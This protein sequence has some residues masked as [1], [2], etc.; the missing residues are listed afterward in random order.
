MDATYQ[1]IQAT[2][3]EGNVD[4]LKQ[5]LATHQIAD[6]EIHSQLSGPY[7]ELTHR[8]IVLSEAMEHFVEYELVKGSYRNAPNEHHGSGAAKSADLAARTAH[9]VQCIDLI[10]TDHSPDSYTDIDELLVVRLRHVYAHVF[11]LKTHLRRLPLMQLQFCIAVFLKLVTGK[12]VNGFDVYA[13]TIDKERLIRFLKTIRDAMT[14][15]TRPVISEDHYVQ[16]VQHLATGPTALKQLSRAPPKRIR[17]Y[18]QRQVKTINPSTLEDIRKHVLPFAE[19]PPPSKQTLKSLYEK[20]IDWDHRKRSS[21]TFKELHETYFITKQHYSI[22]KVI[23]YIDG[24][25][26]GP[27][28]DPPHRQPPVAPSPTRIRA[29]KR[30]LQ[31]IGEMIKSTRESPNITAK[32]SRVLQL[33]TSEALAE[34]T[35][36]LRQFF[37][38]GYS[39]AKWEL[40]A[41]RCDQLGAVFQKIEINLREA[42]RW[43]VYTQTQQNL[44][45]YRRYLAY[46]KRFRTI[47]ALR[48]YIAFVGTEF[49]GSLIETYAPEQL[50]EAKLLVQYM[51][52]S[53]AESSL[54]DPVTKDDLKYIVKDLQLRIN[55]IR[56]ENASVGRTIDEFFFLESYI[57]QPTATVDRVRQT[58]RY[59]LSH[60]QLA[61]RHKLVQKTDLMYARELLAR[62]QLAEPDDTRRYMWS[63]IWTRLSK[64]Q[65]G[66]LDTLVGRTEQR[67]DVA[68][69]A[70][71]KTMHALHLPLDDDEYVQ[72][73]NRR[74]AKSY[75][76]N[77]FVLDNK[78]RVL[79]EIVKDRRAQQ[80]AD[81]RAVPL[82]EQLKTLR[83]QDEHMFQRMFDGL[84]DSMEQILGRCDR[85]TGILPAVTDQ[86]A[87]EYCLLEA[88]EILCNLALFRDNAADLATMP[89]PVVTGRNLR[90]Y[91]AHDMLA[92]D[93]L[94]PC[95]NAVVLN[96]RYLVEH[97]FKLYGAAGAATKLILS[98]KDPPGETLAKKLH[99]K[100]IFQQQTEWTVEQVEFF[101]IVTNFQTSVLQQRIHDASETNSSVDLLLLGRN[102]LDQEIVTIA[103]H[104]NPS[105]FIDQ[106]LNYEA[107]S[108]N[109]FHLLIRYF[110]RDDLVTKIRLL[111]DSPERFCTNLALRYGLVEVLRSL[112]SRGVNEQAMKSIITTEMST[113]FMRYSSELIRELVLLF[114]AEWFVQL[115]DHLGNT[116]LHWAV[117]R[118]DLE[119][120]QFVL[121]RYKMLLRSKNKFGDVPL[122]IAVRYHEDVVVELLLA[123]G[124]DPWIEPKIVQTIA[125]QNRRQLLQR[126]PVDIGRIVAAQ[127]DGH[128]NNPLTA[129]IKANNY[130]LF[131]ELHKRFRYEL[132][133]GDLLHV[134]AR[135]NRVQFL[136]YILTE[137]QTQGADGPTGVDSIS[138]DTSFT[139]LMVACATG[140]FEAAQLLLQHGANGLF[141]NETNTSPWH[142]AVH[143]GNRAIL[144]LLLALNPAV[145]VNAVT[146]DKR[147][148]LSIAIESDQTE[149][150][151]DFLLTTAG[152]TVQ[153]EH[154][155]HACLQGKR[156]MLQLFLNRQPAHI[157]AKDFLQRSPLMIAV[158]LNDATTV[159]YLLDRGADRNA[160]NL[161]GMNCLHV[162]A[163][164]N[165]S[166]ITKVLLAA[167]VD[168]E[169]EDNFGRTPLVVALEAEHL[170]I[171]EQLLHSGASPESAYGYRFKNHRNATLLHKFTLEKRPRVVEY[172]VKKLQFPTDLVD[173][174]GKTAEMLEE[175]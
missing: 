147:S 50:T 27:C 129:A 167:Q 104:A 19:L 17:T 46:L 23:E 116:V 87:L 112:W 9:M 170:T 96:A 143:G 140:H 90:N 88:S 172:L 86:L 33:I 93:T 4:R 95:T 137:R 42:R 16:Y 80:T 132:H 10:L 71:V 127:A 5:L 77:V 43:F 99:F 34:R 164:N 58:V 54:I 49:K 156:N 7:A 79:K 117:L 76:G 53:S 59:I 29:I 124:A 40:E 119:L 1:A 37:S 98:C 41:E 130:E 2:I 134:A 21:R 111:L 160:V 62:L 123:H 89:I 25:R 120:L 92:Y 108:S 61:R 158:I 14:H 65:F 45:I 155:L 22:R 118:S 84:L 82:L 28:N 154:V 24:M 31:V 106:L 136:Q 103:L 101:Q 161:L 145:N 121:C 157:S 151:I 174:D 162:A 30:T 126:M 15:A 138:P 39:L 20:T 94:T 55:A 141:Q 57:R 75:Y 165:L 153:A 149:A 150:Q 56:M 8:N 159:Q 142:C 78:Y 44:L 63:T 51:L 148:A 91:L 3:L 26:E 173:D 18:I 85:T 60:T 70:T 169:A 125:T 64:E 6:G 48:S 38:H 11:F 131:V 144:S 12:P 110:K 133:K 68:L 152:V 163:L 100:E 66:G 72:F 168:R 36:D 102:T 74:L 139:P 35:K 171:V 146:R 73:V 32:L 135:F 81:R 13:F 114:P 52:D 47:E 115:Y 67:V 175:E 69:D 128:T 105:Q 83:K 107:N 109:F 166:G 122:L 113:I 97:R